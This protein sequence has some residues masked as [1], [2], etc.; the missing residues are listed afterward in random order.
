MVLVS[1]V[2]E[3]SGSSHEIMYTCK[4]DK[5]VYVSLIFCLLVFFLFV[6]FSLYLHMFRNKATYMYIIDI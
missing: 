5:Y 3:R 1:P 6:F 4:Y 2:T